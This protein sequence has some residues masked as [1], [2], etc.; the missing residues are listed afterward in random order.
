MRVEEK[1]KRLN[2]LLEKGVGNLKDNELKEARKINFELAEYLE[3]F[4]E[5]K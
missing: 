1:R 4:F 3:S 5:K 2:E